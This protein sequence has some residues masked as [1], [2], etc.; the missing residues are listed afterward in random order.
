LTQ[1][2]AADRLGADGGERRAT[3]NTPVAESLDC[4]VIGAGVVGLAVGRALA[5]AGRE[6]LVLD[7]NP[8]IGEETSS[9]NSEVIHAGIYYP[10]GSLKAQLCV[11]G[12][13][14]LYAYCDSAE[15]PYKQCGKVI[16]AIDASQLARLRTLD[17]QARDNGVHDLE[18]L[19]APALRK[20]EPGVVGA[21]GLWSPSTGIV[22]AHALMV[23]LQADIEK[24]GG[25]VVTSAECVDACDRNGALE[26]TFTSGG[27]RSSLLARTVVNAAGLHASR[28]A[29]MLHGEAVDLPATRYAKG[30]YFAYHGPNPFAHLVYPLPVAG[31]LG[32][33]ATLDLAGKLRFGPDVEWI[34]AIDY[35]VS[36]DR[37]AAFAAAIRSYWPQVVPANLQPGYAGVRPKLHG[38][39]ETAAD[40]IIKRMDAADGNTQIVHLLGIESPGLTASLA[41][42]DYVVETLGQD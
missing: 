17:E 36:N 23:S 21:S 42:G 7:K 11:A 28:V 38:P 20:I 3:R 19:D 10:T 16:V 4:V 22:D 15:I 34:D 6:V 1:A 29:R 24:S 2:A 30:N 35:T 9:R 27:T 8:R 25:A 32:I 12:K 33:H 31:G 5:N 13:A 26:M 37:R 18:W 39:N 40:F 41:I 14:L